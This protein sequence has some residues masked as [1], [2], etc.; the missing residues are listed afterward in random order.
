MP[1]LLQKLQLVL[2][3]RCLMENKDPTWRKIL[4]KKKKKKVNE[5]KTGAE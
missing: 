5:R 1:R 2:A 4:G 3:Y